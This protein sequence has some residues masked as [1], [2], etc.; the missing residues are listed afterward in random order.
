VNFLFTKGRFC[1]AGL[2]DLVLQGQNRKGG[3]QGH[4]GYVLQGTLRVFNAWDRVISQAGLELTV[5]RR[6][7]LNSPLSLPLLWSSYHVWFLQ[8]WVSD[9]G[10]CVF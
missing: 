4:L 6:M 10:F 1:S 8:C 3:S 5:C 9:P 2:C 7:L